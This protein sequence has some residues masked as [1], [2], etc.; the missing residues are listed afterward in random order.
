MVMDSLTKLVKQKRKVETKVTKDN[1]GQI[2]KEINK[3]MD[4]FGYGKIPMNSSVATVNRMK[5]QYMERL[6]YDIVAL[7][8]QQGKDIVAEI[9]GRDLKKSSEYDYKRL[10]QF[11]KELA[12]A[13]KETSRNLTKEQKQFLERGNNNI[14]GFGNNDILTLFENTKNE[15]QAKELIEQVKKQN[16]KEV[17]Y[18]KQTELLDNVFNKI[19]I[20]REDDLKL[21]KEKMRNMEFDKAV[22]YSDY[23]LQ[24]LTLFESGDTGQANTSNVEDE[25]E[26]S[27]ARLDDL[28]IQFGLK[29]DGIKKVQKTLNK[30]KTQYNS[31]NGFIYE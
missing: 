25:T 30:Y 7:A 9:E 23:L 2:I 21:I 29:K 13:K 12:I 20:V 11:A 31:K 18:S 28:M 15:K 6:T 19:G 8:I 1:K 27:N 22:H 5:K 14:K 26:L 17:F 24:G 16:A 3:N 4:S 10:G